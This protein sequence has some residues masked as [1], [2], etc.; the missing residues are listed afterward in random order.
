MSE[1]LHCPISLQLIS[2][3]KQSHQRL[4]HGE[5]GRS[6]QLAQGANI[7]I[8]SVFIQRVRSFGVVSSTYNILA[9]FEHYDLCSYDRYVLTQIKRNLSLPDPNDRQAEMDA[10]K[11]KKKTGL[12]L[13]DGWHSDASKC[14][15]P[16]KLNSE[17]AVT[18]GCYIIIKP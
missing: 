16:L 17:P 18:T 11:E 4:L 13:Y 15:H 8:F 1:S 9:L 6:L 7:A 14:T 2:E 3:T 10:P 5:N 12:I